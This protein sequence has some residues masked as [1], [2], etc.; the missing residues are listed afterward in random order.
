MADYNMDTHPMVAD[1]T[2]LP[3]QYF[4][5]AQKLGPEARMWFAILTDAI[6]T[7]E[8]KRPTTTSGNEFRPKKSNQIY[9][10]TVKW[11]ADTTVRIGSFHFI[12]EIFDLDPDSVRRRLA[13]ANP[14]PRNRPTGMTANRVSTSVYQVHKADQF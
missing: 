6:R 12:C 7:I 13:T 2:I 10:E 5:R 8:L 4:N 14:V 11:F 9:L 1:T 3:S